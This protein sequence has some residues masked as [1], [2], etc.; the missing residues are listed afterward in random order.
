MPDINLKT[1]SAKLGLSQTTVSRGLNG[2]PEVSERT[3][4]RI[5]EAAAQYNYRPNA[6]AQGLA[7][8]RSMRIGHVIPL[9]PEH[10][11]MN[12]VFGDFIAGAGEIYAKAGYEMVLS[13]VGSDLEENAYRD[14]AAKR[15]VDG[16][17]VHSPR[18]DDPRPALLRELGLPF[19]IHGRVTSYD[20]PY[21]FMDMNNRR[22][23]LR[24]TEFLLDLGHTRI[25]LINGWESFEFA[26]RRRSGFVEALGMRGMSVDPSLMASG[27]MTETLGHSTAR[28]MLALAEPPTAFLVSS[29][30]VA[31]GVRRALDDLGLA[32]RRDVSVIA[33]DDVLSYLDNGNALPVYTA[34]RSS[35]RAAGRRCAEMVLDIIANPNAPPVTELWEAELTIG[36]STGRAPNP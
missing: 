31:M 15:S 12:P 10:Q 36:Q 30:M 17:I 29:I 13:V 34:T 28:S 6:G 25:A 7:T 26:A 1:L 14:L 32:I 20:K 2:Y 22:A 11:M 9:N 27:E 5:L 3:R 23:F 18:L 24:A 4:A 33:H 21:S 8:G 16:V 35:V 19:V